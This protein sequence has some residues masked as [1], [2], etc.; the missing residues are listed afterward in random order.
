MNKSLST[1]YD[2]KCVLLLPIV[3]LGSM[4]SSFFLKKRNNFF[5]IEISKRGDDNDR[6]IQTLTFKRDEDSLYCHLRLPRPRLLLS[7]MTAVGPKISASSARA[8]TRKTKQPSP[9]R[10]PPGPFSPPTVSLCFLCFF[11]PFD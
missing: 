10:L 2:E 6:K 11:C 3:K 9:F 5:T 7:A 4:K 8:H 1:N